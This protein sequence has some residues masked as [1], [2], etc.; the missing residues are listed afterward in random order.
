[1]P[2]GPLERAL[3]QVLSGSPIAAREQ[4]RG[5]E[6][7]VSRVSHDAPGETAVGYGL[8]DKLGL[9]VGDATT[10]DISGVEHHVRV[11]GWYRTTE[12]TGQ[13]LL[14]PR[15]DL[16]ADAVPDQYWMTLTPGAS[17]GT[18]KAAL[19]HRL[20]DG[21]NCRPV[22]GQGPGNGSRG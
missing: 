13:I 12:D 20:G 9:R 3:K 10:V 5:Q 17:K 18:V 4:Y 16:G 2:Q 8:L 15:S 1:M 11:V 7:P 22:A 14:M 6:Q 19:A 21:V